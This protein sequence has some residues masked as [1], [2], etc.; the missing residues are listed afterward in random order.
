MA[1]KTPGVEKYSIDGLSLVLSVN[2]RS[3]MIP[4]YRDRI[5]YGLS[6]TLAGVTTA[7]SDL[8]VL[9]ISMQSSKCSTRPSLRSWSWNEVGS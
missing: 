7:T 1:V 9:K 2:V 6:L 3:H 5:H 4:Y 8:D